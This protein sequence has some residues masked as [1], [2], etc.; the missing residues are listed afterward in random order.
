M[1]L[2]IEREGWKNAAL[3]VGYVGNRGVALT[4]AID[5]KA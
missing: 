2:G 3:S 1:E 4:R 5:P